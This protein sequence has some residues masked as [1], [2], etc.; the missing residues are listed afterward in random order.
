MN[1]KVTALYFMV[2]AGL[3]G[4]NFVQATEQKK[5]ESSFK[6]LP[7]K[8][9]VIISASRNAKQYCLKNL[10]STLKQNYKNY[11][12]IWIDDASND[13]TPELVE[14]YLEQHDSD[15]KVTLIKNKQRLWAG[16]NFYRAI[17]TCKDTEIIVVVD[18]DDW[19]KH[20]NVLNVVNKAYENDV[21]LT[22]GNN[23]TT[24]PW[25][26]HWSKQIPK[27]VIED[28]D[29]RNQ[30]WTTGHLR[31]FYAWLF[32][33]IKLNDFIYENEFIKVHWD[34][35]SMIPMVEMAGF[36][37]RFIKEVLYV[38]NNNSE[39]N[40]FN[41]TDYHKKH[42][43]FQKY[44]KAL[45]KYTPLEKKPGFLNCHQRYPKESPH[46]YPSEEELATLRLQWEPVRL[47]ALQRIFQDNVEAKSMLL[48]SIGI[49]TLSTDNRKE[50]TQYTSGSL[51]K[52]CAKWGYGYHEYNGVLD[53]A[54]DPNWSK[55]L[56]VLE[57][58]KRHSEYEWVVWVDDDIVITNP[59]IQL[60]DFIKVYGDKKNLIIS[61]DSP[62]KM[63]PINTGLF[64]LRNNA[65][66]LTF[67]DDVWKIGGYKNY[68]CVRSYMDQE[69]ITD[70]IRDSDK[71]A[72]FT[73]IL[74]IGILQSF[75]RAEK[76]NDVFEARWKKDCFAAHLLGPNTIEERVY[77]A[78]FLVEQGDIPLV[79]P[80]I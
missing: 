9:M 26:Y 68:T 20:D 17:H 37:T 44:F 57:V 15:N 27:K 59:F 24:I 79:A 23:E 32:K 53:A 73:Q 12:I 63:F 31:T 40:D 7:E 49:V 65:E 71:Y 33:K 21:W 25:Q 36:H 67:L 8:P 18:G 5:T 11:R 74:P 28:N 41:N 52:Y 46:L 80:R 39:Y 16:E 10:A 3:L 78:R 45:P 42:L 6:A 48:P 55:I 1:K 77:A 62:H 66:T 75:L 4:T 34:V 30:I 14:D 50:M 47:T 56:A 70:A 19:L 2:I 61:E 38:Y 35:V 60:H 22:Y 72:A 54:R 29:I 43:K 58:M 76:V 51:R 69:A 13:G 64:I